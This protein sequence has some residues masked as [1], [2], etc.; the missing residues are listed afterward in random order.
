MVQIRSFFLFSLVAL[1]VFACV[2][3]SG[4]M[5][6][7]YTVE[8]KVLMEDASQPFGNAVIYLQLEDITDPDKVVVMDTAVIKNG[9]FNHYSYVLVHDGYLNPKGIYTVSAWVDLNGNTQKD[10]GDFVSK[11]IHRLEANILEQPFDI[12]VYPYA[13]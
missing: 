7:A 13:G 5:S 3:V 12:Y 11:P 4:C 2:F 6:T 1:T 10:N 9:S 8:G